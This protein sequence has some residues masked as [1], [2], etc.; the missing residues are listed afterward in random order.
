MY[1][2]LHYAQLPGEHVVSQAYVYGFSTCPYCSQARA[3]L[4]REGISVHA[5]L[6]DRLPRE[7]RQE[8]Q[9]DFTRAYG[10]EPIYPV[11]EIAGELYFGFD[12]EIWKRL[13]LSDSF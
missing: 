13:L 10:A 12:E 5:L 3:F 9:E 11:L 6:L 8:L 1:S 2:D 7:R 4:E